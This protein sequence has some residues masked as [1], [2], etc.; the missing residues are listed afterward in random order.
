M[1]I[2]ILSPF[3]PYRG[4]MAQFSGR[5]YEELKNNHK[6]KAFNFSMLYPSFLFPGK[7]QY[8]TEEDSALIIHSERVLNSINPLSYYKTASQ[9][10]HFHPDILIVPYWMSFVAPSLGV[11]CRLINKKTKVLGL[12][13]NAIPHE[14]RF[15]DKPLAKY[16]F[17]ACD[18]FIALSDPVKEDLKSII[19]DKPIL[20]S[21]HPIYDHYSAKTS[22]SEASSNLG[23]NS[24]KKTLL[25]FGLIREYKGLDI[26][27]KAMDLL[28]NNYQLIIAGECYGDF[29]IYQDIIDSLHNKNNIKVLEEYIPD[30]MVSTLFSASDVLILPYRDATQSGVVA[31][32]YQME[33]PLIA[34]NV[35][36]LGETI[37]KGSTGLVVDNVTPEA[38]AASINQY[39]EEETT[40]KEMYTKNIIK[41]KQRL[42]WNSF[43]KAILEFHS[44]I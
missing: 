21:P 44:S 11:V 13:H 1:K 37:R 35:G 8:V 22:K 38:L 28:D 25:F 6:V 9:I 17:S 31:V 40:N 33:T 4:G 29:R 10:N 30:E 14:K 34:T 39:F 23:M 36:A 27:L 43:S 7:T 19:P 2:A 41:E 24:D 32:A 42:S 15:F 16:F 5:L 20:V 12:I 18:G 26:L 3:Y